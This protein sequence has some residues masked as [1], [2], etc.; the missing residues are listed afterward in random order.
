MNWRIIS[1]LV[2][3]DLTL[4]FRNRFFAFVSVLG[5][6]AYAGIYYVMPSTV[7]ESLEIGLY[8]PTI[9][10][11]IEELMGEEDMIIRAMDSEEALKEAIS[12]GEYIVGVVLA[13][14]ILEKLTTG[15]KAQIKVYFASDFPEELKES[16]II[17]LKELAFMISGHPMNIE[18][19]E[20]IL[21]IDMAGM[22]IPLRNRMRPLFA[23]FVLM[24]E[25][26]GLASLI[27]S[28]IE[29]KTLQALL[30]TP[31]K[32]EGLF[33]G[34]GIMGVG[35]AFV[36]ATL[37]ITVTGGLSKQPFVILV[38]LLLGSLLVTGI[39]FL[40]ASAAKD[41][42]SVMAWGMLVLIILS[43][44]AFSVLFPG[45]ISNWV[46]TI[47]SYYLAD[48]VHQAANFGAGWGEVW[49]N[50]LILL[51]FDIAIIWLGIAVLRRKLI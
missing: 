15:Q 1:A 49:D 44:P 40:M 29:A 38:A 6:V 12:E 42:M 37:L 46:K 23:V 32:V 8:A 51:G 24:I 5:V 22:Q 31:M 7:D 18:V 3:K 34:K 17:L 50:L 43:I 39:G 10:P 21:G 33:L 48:T 13:E 20:E 16:Y 41:I 25:T 35:L 2:L 14:D 11:I 28:E 45:T 47:P 30:I 27:S 36:Q 19:S 9:P 26:M 4:F